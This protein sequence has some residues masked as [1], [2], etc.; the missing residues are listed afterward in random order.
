MDGKPPYADTA[1]HRLGI[2]SADTAPH[3]LVINGLGLACPPDELLQD[4]QAQ[5]AARKAEL[6]AL[7]EAEMLRIDAGLKF[8]TAKSQDL[9]RDGDKAIRPPLYAADSIA[10]RFKAQSQQLHTKAEKAQEINLQ[11]EALRA[12]QTKAQ[13]YGQKTARILDEIKRDWPQKSSTQQPT[14]I[15]GCHLAPRAAPLK[16]F[17]AGSS[18]LETQS[19]FVTDILRQLDLT[20]G[21]D[22][23][24]VPQWIGDF[25]TTDVRRRTGMLVERFSTFEL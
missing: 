17:Y 22:D 19:A 16:K 13:L 6:K 18:A 21:P 5:F 2:P 8:V 24:V 9:P 11:Q 10:Q 20:C 25:Q 4:T 7:Y 15:R 23:A 14:R 12:V 3:R 1:P